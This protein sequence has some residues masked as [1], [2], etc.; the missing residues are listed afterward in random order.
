[1][2]LQAVE[3]LQEC[4]FHIPEKALR[5]GIA[6]V[7][8]STGLHG[9]WECFGKEPLLICETAHNEDGVREMLG[10]L[11]QIEYHTLH[12]IYG[13]VNDKDF[14]HILELI[15][16]VGQGHP[17]KYYY[18]QPSVPRGLAVDLLASKA[19]ELGFQGPSFPQVGQAIAHARTHSTKRDLILVTGS[20]FLIADAVAFL[21]R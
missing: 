1:M 6:Q 3:K 4:G 16:Q 11:S 19:E 21:R 2:A 15:G 20:I 17:T 10:K 18:T 14:G 12:I 7:V 5:D 9:R 13:C 8:A